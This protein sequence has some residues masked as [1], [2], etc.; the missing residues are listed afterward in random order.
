MN[1]FVTEFTEG[2]VA[3]AADR[4]DVTAIRLVALSAKSLLAGSAGVSARDVVSRHHRRKLDELKD[5]RAAEGPGGG[6]LSAAA[7]QHQAKRLHALT[8]ALRRCSAE[9]LDSIVD[10]KVARR[11]CKMF[12]LGDAAYATWQRR[13]S[14]RQAKRRAASRA[15]SPGAPAIA[16]PSPSPTKRLGKRK[17]P[18]RAAAAAAA[19]AMCSRF[20]PAA[21]RTAAA[22]GGGSDAAGGPAADEGEG[23]EPSPLVRRRSSSDGDEA[24]AIRPRQL[25]PDGGT[26]GQKEGSSD[27]DMDV[28]VDLTYAGDAAA[29]AA[30]A[31]LVPAAAAAGAPG[32]CA[33]WAAFYSHLASP[34][35]TR[36]AAAAHRAAA[37]AAAP[38]QP[39]SPNLSPQLAPVAP[40]LVA[41]R[42]AQQV[43]GE[44]VEGQ[45]SA[46][47]RMLSAAGRILAGSAS[48]GT[49][50]AAAA[51]L[52][53]GAPLPLSPSRLA[54]L[55]A[56]PAVTPLHKLLQPIDFACAGA[57][58][59]GW[60]AAPP[61]A[62]PR[63][64]GSKENGGGAGPALSRALQLLRSP[65]TAAAA[66]DVDWT[67]D[68]ADAEAA[69]DVMM[70]LAPREEAST[71]RSSPLDGGGG[72]GDGRSG[73]RAAR[74]PDVAGVAG[75]TLPASS[76]TVGRRG[77]G[78]E[79]G[80][81]EKGEEAPAVGPWLAAAAMP[82]GTLGLS[83][84]D[85]FMLMCQ[86]QVFEAAA[87]ARAG[88]GGAEG[89]QG[90]AD[91]LRALDVR[92]R[93]HSIARPLRVRAQPSL[94]GGAAY[95][96][97]A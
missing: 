49:L 11:M 66:V 91:A 51:A 29:V 64:G 85:R 20:A 18:E 50:Q 16:S 17:S 88:G 87:A 86:A 94:A 45:C 9:Q 52:P 2:G 5:A 42:G 69:A 96:V 68:A 3:E 67:R 1:S 61:A 36:P 56:P 82:P 6:G 55:L 62:A 93:G 33:E 12:G 8:A 41:A 79:G 31:T 80:Q 71:S 15:G 25:F 81:R 53:A 4:T 54:Q 37:P 57:A 76:P 95:V 47:E 27:D 21:A 35:A 10:Q 92:G 30:R 19:R 13:N 28:D 44:G 63:G 77:S 46:A 58:A 89:V 60:G 14:A 32:G 59:A 48:P 39:P 23:W 83:A 97:A 65:A 72:G 34:P 78:E 74:S 22:Q 40:E 90:A 73:G 24:A 7:F 84:G 70:S 75:A 26:A 38:A 43:C